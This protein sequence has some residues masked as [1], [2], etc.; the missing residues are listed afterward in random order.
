[1]SA[2]SSTSRCSRSSA[3]PRSRAATTARRSRGSRRR[4]LRRPRRD[5][6]GQHNR[7][8][9]AERLPLLP[10]PGDGR[11]GD[12]RCDRRGGCGGRGARAGGPRTIEI[13]PG[14]AANGDRRRRGYRGVPVHELRFASSTPAFDR[15]VNVYGSMDGKAYFVA[16]GGRLYRFGETGETTLPA[17]QPLPLSADPDRKRRRRAAAQPACDPARVPRLPPARARL[18]AALPR[19]LRRPARAAGLRLRAAARGTRDA[20]RRRA[21]PG[22]PERG[23]R[24]ARRHALVRRAASAA[25]PGRAGAG[26]GGARRGGLLRPRR[27][28][29][30]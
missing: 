23:L 15:P 30:E 22:A 3:A 8:L 5:A 21:R 4:D 9:P 27:R 11:E 10:H 18:H 17:Q 24:A 7:R 12:Q 13:D 25:D 20:R 1:M 16:G 19:A 2:S 29:A 26:G 6:R 28:T 14:G